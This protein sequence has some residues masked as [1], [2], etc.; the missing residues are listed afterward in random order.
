LGNLLITIDRYDKAE[1]VCHIILDQTTDQLEKASMYNMLGM[2]KNGQGKYKEAIQFHKKSIEMKQKMLT[3]THS[4]LT[5]SY[6]NIGLVYS[7]MGKYS[8][9]FSAYEKALEIKKKLSLEIIEI[10]LFLTTTSVR[11]IAK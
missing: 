1:Q 9:A 3:S 5:S 2:V 10:W 4:Y 6:N 7:K 8:E 11:C